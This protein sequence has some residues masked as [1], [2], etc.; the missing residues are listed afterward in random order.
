ML[1]A[2]LSRISTLLIKLGMPLVY[3]YH[4]LC[5]SFFLNVSDAN[6]PFLEKTA[7]TA[8]IPFQYLFEGKV[9]FSAGNTYHFENRFDYTNHFFTKTA[10]AITL[11]PLSLPV[12]TFLKACCYLS[13]ETR[14]HAAQIQE[15]WHHP[16]VHSNVEM[17]KTVGIAINDWTSADWIDKPQYKRREEQEQN[18]KADIEA[19]RCIVDL[20]EEAHIP[21]WMDCGSCLGAYRYGGVI[22]WDWDID[23]AILAPDFDNVRSV[24]SALDPEKYALQDWS[25]RDKPKTYLKVYVKESQN[26]IDIYHF[27]FD[28]QKQQLFTILSN[29]LNIFLPLSWKIRELR[30]T[31]PMPF[32]YVFP[33]KRA[34]FE[35]IEVPVPCQITAYL[36]TF[37]GKNLAPA[38]LYNEITQE[39]EKDPTHP[40]WQLPCAH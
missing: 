24:L 26:L 21:F 15:A 8:L 16:E 37:Y 25:G 32:S 30:Y 39:Y 9:A 19:L 18:L 38:K 11:L 20:L 33:L 5:T 13:P 36:Q 27:G 14:R 17:Y 2:L 29:E 35:G 10:C 40:Y 3:V 1:N 4:L 31:A 23:L 34:L 28:P 22:P 6:A 7:N 12:G